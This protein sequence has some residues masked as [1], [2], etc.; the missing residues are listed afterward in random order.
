[1][2]LMKKLSKN[3]ATIILL[4]L[5]IKSNRKVGN[6]LSTFVTNQLGYSFKSSPLQW[7]HWK[8]RSMSDR[9]IINS[10]GRPFL[11]T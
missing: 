5:G 7:L 3:D 6:S 2:E 8:M 11:T 10:K 4:Y 9:E 1:M